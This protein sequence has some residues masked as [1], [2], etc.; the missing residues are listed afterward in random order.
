MIAAVIRLIGL[1][2]AILIVLLVYYEGFPFLRNIPFI[3]RVPV[4]RE[5][6]T[7]RVASE[8]V[9]AADEARQGY[10]LLAE[11]TLAE[12]KAKK[13]QED[14]EKTAKVL[15]YYRKELVKVYS[16]QAAEDEQLKT[17]RADYEKKLKASGK[18]RDGLTDDDIIWLRRRGID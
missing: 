4:V 5:L 10:V 8:R 17:E 18:S 11:K 2:A 16:E 3:D 1:P 6:I 12:A 15:D 14:A 7:G 13:L 9:K